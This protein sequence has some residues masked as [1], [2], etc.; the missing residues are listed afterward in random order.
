ME[1]ERGRDG[2]WTGLV[3]DNDDVSDDDD[4]NDDDGNNDDGDDGDARLLPGRQKDQTKFRFFNSLRSILD[5]MSRY[6]LIQ[7]RH[8]FPFI[9]AD[10]FDMCLSVDCGDRCECPVAICAGWIGVA[11]GHTGKAE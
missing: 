11:A 5:I 7:L 3:D 10:A 6:I 2:D 1:G 9:L 8:P 4:G